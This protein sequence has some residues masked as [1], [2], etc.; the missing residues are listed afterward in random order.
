[1]TTNTKLK[2][3][4]I[5]A[6][7]AVAI[8]LAG[9]GGGGGGGSPVVSAP[10]AEAPTVAVA[11]LTPGTTVEPG[12]QVTGATDELSALAAA[13][14]DIEVPAEGYAPGETVSIPGIC[15]LTCT[16]DVNCSVMVA[17]DGAI[18][19]VGTIEISET[20]VGGDP[21]TPVDPTTPAPPTAAETL[22]DARAALEAL[23]DDATDEAK[24]MAQGLV[25]DALRLPGNEAELILSLDA[26]VAQAEERQLE[27]DLTEK[28]RQDN[29][30]ALENAE[31][32]L[33]SASAEDEEAAQAAVDKALQLPGNEAALIA[34]LKKQ[35]ADQ[36][37]TVAD[38]EAKKAKDERIAREAAVRT[39]IEL[40]DNRVG[41]TA[42]LSPTGITATEISVTRDA[43]GAVTIDVN[44][45][46]DN[47][48]AGGEVTAG[49]G[50]WTSATLTKTDAGTEATD[51]LV[52]YTDIAAPK[53][54][55]FTAEYTQAMLDDA[56]NEARLA[57][58]MSSGF[59]S[60]PGTTWVYT[61]ADDER[62]KTVTGTFDG[63]AGQFTCIMTTCEVET[64]SDGKL[65]GTDASDW[66]FTPAAPLTAT[67][68]DPD[69]AYAYFGWWLN[70]TSGGNY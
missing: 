40:T 49:D 39:A 15:D 62:A 26:K 27:L 46:D 42:K 22:A 36:A 66:R 6:L 29:A 64:N 47:L 2:Y 10:P 3:L 41:T 17:E 18:T 63:V 1:M 5:A 33:A 68:K 13:V 28:E 30:V 25:Y 21:T 16:G 51:T 44:G 8:A 9:C 19:T 48:Y 11:D 55:L 70:N 23:P 38:A 4:P 53:D 54:K 12:T 35:I 24:E 32:T 57:K 14:A 60:A 45:D 56:L 61:G 58:A 31:A 69:V 43:D 59:P 37:Q 65:M 20:M 50:A 7:A 67:I 34:S 52:I